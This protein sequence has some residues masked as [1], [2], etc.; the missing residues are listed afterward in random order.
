MF[1]NEVAGA[2]FAGRADGTFLDRLELEVH[3]LR[4]DGAGAER[5]VPI[6]DWIDIAVFGEEEAGKDGGSVLFSVGDV[7]APRQSRS[8]S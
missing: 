4:T 6:D 8:R 3:K 1:D 2:P 5:E 7:S